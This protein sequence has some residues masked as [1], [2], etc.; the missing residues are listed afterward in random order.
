MKPGQI[1]D[2]VALAGAGPILQVEVN[3]PQPLINL[4]SSQNKPIPASSPGFALIDTGASR[5]CIDSSVLSKL[6][7]NPIG[8]VT[9]GTTGGS[10]T[11]QLFPAKL[12]F[13]VITLVIDFGSVVGVNLQGQQ[14]N[15]TPIVALIGRDVLSRCLLIY[16]G[17]GGF[18]TLAL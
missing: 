14:I 13:S 4:L 12:S 18:F 10:T 6:G 15:G 16:S 17:T 1:H 8:V 11:C 2:P 9:M 5:T 7:I 3:L